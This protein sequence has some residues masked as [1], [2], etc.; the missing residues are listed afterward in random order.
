LPRYSAA[1]P[2]SAI[3]VVD[4]DQFLGAIGPH[5]DHHERA[6]AIVVESGVEVDAVGPQT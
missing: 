4:R 5:A 6:Q 1:S 3:A 2:R